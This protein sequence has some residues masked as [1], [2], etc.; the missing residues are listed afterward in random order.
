M[1]MG[2]ASRVYEVDDAWE[3]YEL[4]CQRGWTDG[5]PVLP[6]TEQRVTAIL[7]YLQRDPQEVLGLMPPKGGKVTVEKVAINAAMAGCLPEFV[8]IVIAA[9]ECVLETSDSQHFNLKGVNETTN[10]VTPLIIVS[11]P[12]VNQLGFHY[13]ENAFGGGNASRANVTV[14]RALRLVLWNGSG[15]RPGVTD[16]TSL[17]HPGK[18]SFCI[19]ENPSPEEN[20]WTKLNVEWGYDPQQSIVVVFGCEAPRNILTYE[21]GSVTRN[22]LGILRLMADSMATPGSNNG[23]LLGQILAVFGPKTAS[24]LKADGWTKETVRTFLWEEARNNLKSLVERGFHDPATGNQAWR[25]HIPWL[26]QTNLQNRAP[27]T[28]REENILIA[29]TGGR[30]LQW[31]AICHGWGYFG[32]YA[33]ARPIQFPGLSA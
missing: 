21:G 10:P 18:F 14:G 30:R 17:G 22:S 33:V 32:G 28:E 3:F 26:D 16:M 19:A 31:N 29:V 11:G 13:H 2:L 9:I 27:I 12:A 8:P 23:H 6:P 24:T 15:A 25:A 20:P 5:A 1:Q 7:D 4:A